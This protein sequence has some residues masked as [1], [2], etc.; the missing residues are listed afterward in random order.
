[1]AYAC[2]KRNSKYLVLVTLGIFIVYIPLNVLFVITIGWTDN[3]KSRGVKQ[4]EADSGKLHLSMYLLGNTVGR[5][6]FI[7]N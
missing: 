5:V 1:M 2:N 3:I 7:P 4:V 6:L